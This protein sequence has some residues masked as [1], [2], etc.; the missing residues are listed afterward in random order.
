MNILAIVLGFTIIIILNSKKVNMSICLLAGAITTGFL[1]GLNIREMTYYILQTIKDPMTVRLMI[2]IAVISGLGYLLQDNNDLEKMIDSLYKLISNYKILTVTIPAIIGTLAVPGGAILS[3]PMIKKSANKI[4]L[5]G[6]QKASI[7]IFYRHIIFFVYPLFNAIIMSAELFSVSK[8]AIIKY[9]FFIFLAGLIPS[10]FIFFNHKNNNVSN[11]NIDKKINKNKANIIA[12]I[13][14]FS[15]VLTILL[16]AIVFKIPFQ[17]AVFGGLLIGAGRNLK[18]DKKVFLYW[19]RIKKFFTEGINYSL[20]ALIFGIMYF[21]L[22]IENSGAVEVVA[23]RLAASGIP[24][25]FMIVAM[26]IT[27]GYITGL[28]IA[29]LGVL[30]PIF[31][32]LFPEDN[33]VPYISLLFTSSFAGYL[34]SP[35]HMCFILTKEYFNTKV[36][37]TYKYL[38]IPLALMLLTGILQIVLKF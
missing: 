27:S 19:Q 16:L 20:I 6:A 1:T 14:S 23:D 10:Y 22:V 11:N 15:P 17:Y 28:N 2:I 29:A 34:I 5:S 12:F 37:S 3:A 26:G 31:I 8:Y 38:I 13:S 7:N 4:N 33:I 18:G 36:L 21:K 35:L 32:P 9:N 30:I 24:L 25:I